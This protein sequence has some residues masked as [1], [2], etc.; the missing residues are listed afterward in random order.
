M[1][2]GRRIN[3]CQPS[4]SKH[5]LG[6]IVPSA[7]NLPSYS[8]SDAGKIV[9]RLGETKDRKWVIKPANLSN[10]ASVSSRRARKNDSGAPDDA[11]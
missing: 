4:I 6:A 1:P 7:N 3:N 10:G 5:N 8:T 11:R 2:G 9:A